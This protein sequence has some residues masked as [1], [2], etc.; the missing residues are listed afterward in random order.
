MSEKSEETSNNCDV[1]SEES[2]SLISRT[3][4]NFLFGPLLSVLPKKYISRQFISGFLLSIFLFWLYSSKGLLVIDHSPHMIALYVIIALTTAELIRKNFPILNNW[5]SNDQKSLI[6]FKNIDS[7]TD[8]QMHRFVRFHIFSSKCINKLV[9]IVKQDINR[10]PPDILEY[11]LTTQDLTK[12]NLD[13]IFSN[14]IVIDENIVK[15]IL[16]HKM[17]QLTEQNIL[18]IFEKFKEKSEIIKLLFATQQGSKKL[19]EGGRN[20]ELLPYFEN[21]QKQKNYLDKWL[22]IFPVSWSFLSR[23]KTMM[24]YLFVSLAII[25]FLII[26]VLVI[27]FVSTCEVPNCPTT[28]TFFSVIFNLW[29]ITTVITLGLSKYLVNMFTEMYIRHFI[30]RVETA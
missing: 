19:I 20:K 3:L 12:E 15:T 13:L 16:F 25:L 18:N 9:L 14:E 5:F 23:R 30:S 29:I 28:T 2:E 4:D 6:F 1:K 21:Y 26:A 24:I 8:D 10:I 22:K 27:I 17:N 7:M 11:A